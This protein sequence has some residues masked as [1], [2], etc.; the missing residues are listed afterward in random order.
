ML[1][2]TEERYSSVVG[3]T[4]SIFSSVDLGGRQQPYHPNEAPAAVLQLT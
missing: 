4:L 2:Q 3:P 1:L